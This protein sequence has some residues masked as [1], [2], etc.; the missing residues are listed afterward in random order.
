MYG[1]NAPLCLRKNKRARTTRTGENAWIE[2]LSMKHRDDIW[3]PFY[4][5]WINKSIAITNNSDFTE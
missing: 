5:C 3:N 2:C 4:E 1:K